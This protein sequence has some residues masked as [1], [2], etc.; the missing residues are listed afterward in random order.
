MLVCKISV[1]LVKRLCFQKENPNRF[2]SP[3]FIWNVKADGSH[4]QNCYYLTVATPRWFW[5][6]Y[7]TLCVLLL[8]LLCSTKQRI[9]RGMKKSVNQFPSIFATDPS[10]PQHGHYMDFWWSVSE[11]I[12]QTITK[13]KG[14]KTC[15][16]FCS[17]DRTGFVE[18][19]S[20]SIFSVLLFVTIML[21]IRLRF[22]ITC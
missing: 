17:N 9:S 21:P 6:S 4:H 13:D 15:I 14:K 1:N 16:S 2:C 5:F 18:T 7:I 12:E 3:T 19:F 11:E 20:G 10:A 8:K 22:C